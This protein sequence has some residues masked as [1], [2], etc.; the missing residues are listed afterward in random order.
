[1]YRPISNYLYSKKSIKNVS[2]SPILS[3]KIPVQS[4]QRKFETNVRYRSQAMT[5][6]FM[7]E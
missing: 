6:F 2:P 7:S 1:M 3:W 4:Y 5:G